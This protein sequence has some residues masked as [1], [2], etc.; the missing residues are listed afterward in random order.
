MH[1]DDDGIETH[2]NE[3]HTLFKSAYEERFMKRSTKRR[4]SGHENEKRTMKG[5]NQFPILL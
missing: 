2:G 1:Y 3:R 4:T 5:G